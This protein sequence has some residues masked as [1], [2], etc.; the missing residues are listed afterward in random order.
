[1]KLEF[2]ILLNNVVEFMKYKPHY[3]IY[4]LQALMRELSDKELN[5]FSLNSM[6]TKIAKEVQPSTFNKMYSVIKQFLLTY[7]AQNE[8]QIISYFHLKKP[9]HFYEKGLYNEYLKKKNR[10]NK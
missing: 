9:R 5:I 4:T 8:P 1:M 10:K 6:L 2:K 3:Y 7:Y